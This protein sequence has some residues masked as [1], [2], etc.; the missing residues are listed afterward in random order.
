MRI[1][2]NIDLLDF[3]KIKSE[4]KIKNDS[5]T[6]LEVVKTRLEIMGTSQAQFARCVSVTPAQMGLFLRDRGSL[7]EKSLI[8]IMDFIGINIPMYSERL[9][10]A[11]DIAN[12]LRLRG[13]TNIDNWTKE[14]LVSL[15]KKNQIL[16][17]FDVKSKKLYKTL[18]E[19]GKVDMESTYPYFKALVSY[20]LSLDDSKLLTASDAKTKL[21]I[22]LSHSIDSDIKDKIDIDFHRTQCGALTL[23]SSL[24]EKAIEFIE[25]D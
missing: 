10:L 24:H 9:E 23:F 11:K 25:E 15:T 19:S 14:D 2:D 21:E 20:I 22:L 1:I 18:L 13:I 17:F 8:K 16:V 7:T 5:P 12:Y 4:D 6:I 3:T